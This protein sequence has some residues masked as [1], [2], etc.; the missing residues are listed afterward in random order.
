MRRTPAHD[1]LCNG[2]QEFADGGISG[3]DFAS[4]LSME[5]KTN[6]E[7]G[8]KYGGGARET[9]TCERGLGMRE[10]SGGMRVAVQR[11]QAA[12]R[13]GIAAERIVNCRPLDRLLAWLA[14]PSSER[15][16]P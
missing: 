6:Q 3:T 7:R 15:R 8:R 13:Q 2:I 1:A 10:L 11:E 9:R 16:R 5:K 14:H 12:S 4:L